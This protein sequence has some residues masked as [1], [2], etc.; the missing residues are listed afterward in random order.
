LKGPPEEKES[1]CLTMYGKV[2]EKLKYVT[3]EK[4]E[5]WR[6][7]EGGGLPK[8]VSGEKGKGKKEALFPREAKGS[9]KL[10]G[11]F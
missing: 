6:K 7:E 2:G 9:P 4:K 1:P 5:Q 11:R 10:R 3:V 8:P